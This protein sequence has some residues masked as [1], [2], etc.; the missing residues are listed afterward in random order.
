[1]IPDNEEHQNIAFM[2]ETIAILLDQG[3][4]QERKMEEDG[5]H[6]YLTKPF[7]TKPRIE[8]SDL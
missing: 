4:K 2:D 5:L 7:D 6:I 1:M 3:W 8:F